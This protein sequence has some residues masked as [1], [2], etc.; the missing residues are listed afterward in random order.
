MGINDI[1]QNEQAGSY[2]KRQQL[3]FRYTFFTLIDLCVLNLFNQYWDLV[4]LEHFTISLMT[5]VLLQ[6]LLQVAMAVE[7][8]VARLFKGQSGTK[9]K[10][11]R[12]ISAW[13]V[14]FVSKLVILEAINIFFGDSVLFSGPVHGLVAFIVVVT[15]IIVAEQLFSWIYRSLGQTHRIS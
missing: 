8:Q 10:V 12:G 9:A 13:A 5:A 1:L 4:Y 2:S 14:I 3:F 7:H 11:L 15:A 6:V